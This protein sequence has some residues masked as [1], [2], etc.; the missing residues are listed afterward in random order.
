MSPAVIIKHSK[1]SSK[2]LTKKQKLQAAFAG[3]YDDEDLID[4][5]SP[6]QVSTWTAGRIAHT[7]TIDD[8]TMEDVGDQMSLD[9][10]GDNV[11]VATKMVMEKVSVEGPAEGGI[12][13]TEWLGTSHFYL[14]PLL[15]LQKAVRR[16]SHMGIF[17]LTS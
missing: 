11:D 16:L 9:V 8:I 14:A 7:H 5:Q 12:I 10:K 6:V 4:L 3:L 13:R 15:D 2:H 1:P 17:L